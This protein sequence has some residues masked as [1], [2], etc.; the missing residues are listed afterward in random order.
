MLLYHEVIVYKI[1][2]TSKVN[3]SYWIPFLDWQIDVHE[4]KRI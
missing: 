4:L 1:Q 2:C 3:F